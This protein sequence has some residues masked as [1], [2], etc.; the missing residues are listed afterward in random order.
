MKNLLIRIGKYQ[1]NMKNEGPRRFSHMG[2]ACF[3]E[4]VWM[5]KKK[6]VSEKDNT[7][8]YTLLS[9]PPPP[10]LSSLSE[11]RR[12]KGLTIKIKIK[13]KKKTENRRV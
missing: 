13:L 4:I 3:N 1:E 6:N 2:P 7:T 10:P 12:N 11:Q 8:Q 9:P 5:G